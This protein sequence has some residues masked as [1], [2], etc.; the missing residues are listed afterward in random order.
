MSDDYIVVTISGC[1][2]SSHHQ[3]A[4]R[5]THW[6]AARPQCQPVRKSLGER[7]LEYP[8]VFQCG[9]WKVVGELLI[10]LHV[11][12]MYNMAP[13]KHGPS[14]IKP[15][16]KHICRDGGHTRVIYIPFATISDIGGGMLV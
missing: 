11:S 13:T 1:E 9:R 12:A 16:S 4:T 2:G 10:A 3:Q 5:H 6:L 7:R 8:T 14:E 15:S